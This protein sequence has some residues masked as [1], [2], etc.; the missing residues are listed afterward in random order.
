MVTVN[1][2]IAEAPAFWE[3]LGFML[4]RRDGHTHVFDP[5]NANVPTVSA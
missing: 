4:D 3:A 1:A 2:G 5:Q